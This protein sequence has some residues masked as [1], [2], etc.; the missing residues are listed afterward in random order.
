[1]YTV[2]QTWL[3]SFFHVLQ[4]QF[5]CP[6]RRPD[7]VHWKKQISNK[8][9]PQLQN[10]I[11]CDYIL[12]RSPGIVKH[13]PLRN[14]KIEV[15]LPVWVISLMSKTAQTDSGVNLKN[16]YLESFPT[17]WSRPLTASSTE[18]KNDGSCTST[19]SYA[20]IACTGTT[21]LYLQE[22]RSSNNFC[23]ESKAIHWAQMGENKITWWCFPSLREIG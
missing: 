8:C 20:F 22:F 21:L 7:I 19:P 9:M 23:E 1:M 11:S 6:K 12:G 16:G 3:V 14:R 4:M 13:Y 2:V 10:L 18:V 15:R 17:S 5:H